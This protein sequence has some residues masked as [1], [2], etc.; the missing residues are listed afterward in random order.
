MAVFTS[1]RTSTGTRSASLCGSVMAASPEEE[2]PS[3]R[4]RFP[5]PGPGSMVGSN[6]GFVDSGA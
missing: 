3:G 1:V 4:A 2:P 5:V 6:R